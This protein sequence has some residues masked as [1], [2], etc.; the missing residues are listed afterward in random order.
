MFSYEF[1]V[2]KLCIAPLLLQQF[3]VI[4]INLWN[5]S[6]SEDFRCHRPKLQKVPA[7]SLEVSFHE[8]TKNN[9]A[10]SE[11]DSSD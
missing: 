4:K 10:S 5:I 2:Q 6:F 3:H 8:I 11:S 9:I 1:L 7:H